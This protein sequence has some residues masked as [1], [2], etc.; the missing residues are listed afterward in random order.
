MTAFE[1]MCIGFLMGAIVTIISVLTGAYA[2]DRTNQR[3]SD[4]H[5]SVCIRS[6]SRNSN[7]GGDN[8]NDTQLEEAPLGYNPYQE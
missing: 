7:R 4:K 8:G 2:N 1:G 6:D 3:K 5:N